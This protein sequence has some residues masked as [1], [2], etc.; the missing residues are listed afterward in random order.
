MNRRLAGELWDLH[1]GQLWGVDYWIA[2]SKKIGMERLIH[3]GTPHGEKWQ[4]WSRSVRRLGASEAS[5]WGIELL[6]VWSRSVITFSCNLPL[7]VYNT[8]N[9]CLSCVNQTASLIQ[10]P[11]PLVMICIRLD[12]CRPFYIIWTRIL[13]IFQLSV[14]DLNLL[15]FT[16]TMVKTIVFVILIIIRLHHNQ[17]WRLL[18]LSFLLLFFLSF[19]PNEV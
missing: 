1:Q 13:Q 5:P 14:C 19:F 18:F 6:Y 3:D 16:I 8:M 4:F 11:L 2:V 9:T 17:W 10:S 7:E 12:C 15:G